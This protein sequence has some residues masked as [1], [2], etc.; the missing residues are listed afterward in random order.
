MAAFFLLFSF[1][2]VLNVVSQT[3][4][5][6]P[7]TYSWAGFTLDSSGT[8]LTAAQY[9]TNSSSYNGQ[10]YYS[11]DAGSTWEVS[12]APALGYSGIAGSSSGAV[13][14]AIGYFLFPYVSTDYGSTWLKKT[15]PQSTGSVAISGNGQCMAYVNVDTGISYSSNQGA[16]WSTV[17][18]AYK[19][20]AVGLDS[21]GTNVVIAV[22]VVGLYYSGNSGSTFSLQYSDST[23]YWTSS[24]AFSAG[25]S[26]YA[27]T[28]SSG[29]ILVSTNYGSTWSATQG[30]YL[31]IIYLS[32]DS[33]GQ[34][35][36]AIIGFGGAQLYF[37]TNGGTSFTQLTT[38]NSN[39][40][41]LNGDGNFMLYN[42]NSSSLSPSSAYSA[43]P[44]K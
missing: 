23:V 21:T 3:L 22:N 4:Q 40:C 20:Q 29:S 33:S 24:I 5:N 8:Y 10:I 13:L 39:F 38:G 34:N 43:N 7:E 11:Q 36:L 12:N 37:S 35:V 25:S 32:V 44:S 28:G 18:P 16:S 19:A 14:V 6:L 1:S 27:G 26:V 41:V 2:L 17:G 42:Y 30:K 9:R 31:K 15:G